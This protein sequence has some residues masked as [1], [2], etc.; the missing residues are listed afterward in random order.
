LNLLHRIYYFFNG[1]LYCILIK[2]KEIKLS[3][4]KKIKNSQNM[5]QWLKITMLTYSLEGRHSHPNNV[6]EK[7][8]TKNETIYN[9]IQI[10]AS[11]L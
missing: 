6:K 9:R 1:I 8:K 7:K 3:V 4:M 2:V 5:L 11:I 10:H